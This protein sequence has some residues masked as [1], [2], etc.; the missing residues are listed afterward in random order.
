[1]LFVVVVLLVGK[2]GREN[3]SGLTDEDIR[4]TFAPDRLGGNAEKSVVLLGTSLLKF[5]LPYDEELKNEAL[6][7]GVDLDFV[8]LTRSRNLY[9]PFTLLFDDIRNNPPA[10]LFLQAELFFV[11]FDCD[12]V[13]KSDLSKVTIVS[14][15]TRAGK[16]VYEASRATRSFYARVKH[17]LKLLRR[18]IIQRIT[19]DTSHSL[20]SDY[21]IRK[22]MD[23]EATAEKILNNRSRCTVRVSGD[24]FPA[25]VKRFISD[26]RRKGTRVFLLEMNRSQ[27]G[28]SVIGDEFRQKLSTTLQD[29]AVINGLEFWSFSAL[30]A[31]YYIDIAHLNSSGRI[32][33]T[34]WFLGKLTQVISHD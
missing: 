23:R 34:Q 18:G 3:A 11:S 19:Q 30:P 5:G 32:E 14:P 9:Q 31:Q 24:D 16:F 29:V 2:D 21:E 10:Y 20:Q 28:N 13:E 4:A 22:S 12:Q 7:R 15:A 25:E 6:Q 17:Y 1:M 33:F 8:R 26:I 27:E